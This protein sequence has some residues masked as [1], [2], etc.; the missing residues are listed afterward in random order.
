ML[1]RRFSSRRGRSNSATTQDTQNRA[2][3]LNDDL[4]P[5]YSGPS[6]SGTENEDTEVCID[7]AIAREYCVELCPHELLLFRAVQGMANLPGFKKWPFEEIAG[8]NRAVSPHHGIIHEDSSDRSC[9]CHIDPTDTSRWPHYGKSTFRYGAFPGLH[10]GV[11]LETD[12][13]FE[14]K[15]FPKDVE[16]THD[17][18]RIFDS[19]PQVALCPHHSL[20][21]FADP[22]RILTAIK[23]YKRETDPILNRKLEIS[24]ESY[25]VCK[26][27]HSWFR[28]K[29]DTDAY[30]A[31]STFRLLGRGQ[32]PKD[33]IWLS[34]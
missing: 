31:V 14:L 21:G 19:Y 25:D 8:F 34:Q 9:V 2:S 33:P 1:K 3:G 28:F 16:T 23:S 11:L 20:L 6:S 17:V 24:L 13:Y 27:C 18:Q 5:P 4:P 26:H 32:S 7:E 22:Q 12:W 29:L 15:Q 10:R 30:F